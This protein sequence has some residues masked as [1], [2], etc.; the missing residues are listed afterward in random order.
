MTTRYDA[1]GS[2]ATFEPGSRQRVL[3]NLLGIRSVREMAEAESQALLT[4]QERLVNHFAADHRFTASDV[5]MTHRTWLG[6]IYP[7]AGDSVQ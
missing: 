6:A 3:S 5:C 4:A 2:Q 7:C 1:S